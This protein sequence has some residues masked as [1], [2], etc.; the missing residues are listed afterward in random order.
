MDSLGRPQGHYVRKGGGVIEQEPREYIADILCEI[1]LRRDLT[2]EMNAQ[3]RPEVCAHRTAECR[4]V[5][6]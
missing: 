3:P 5:Q 6:T 4:L 2:L 1:G